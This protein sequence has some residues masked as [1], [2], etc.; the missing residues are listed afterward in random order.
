[1]PP[2][3]VMARHSC[4]VCQ[5]AF[6]MG[7]PLITVSIAITSP[8]SHYGVLAVVCVYQK[9]VLTLLNIVYTTTLCIYYR[10]KRTPY[11]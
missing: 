4:C 9:I 1:M 3:L 7:A 11:S 2:A 6:I 10:E 5:H 8:E